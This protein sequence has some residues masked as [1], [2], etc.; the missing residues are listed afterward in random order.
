MIRGKVRKCLLG[1]FLVVVVVTAAVNV[2]ANFIPVSGPL[3]SPN[4][5]T[6]RLALAAVVAVGAILTVA[7]VFGRQKRSKE[8]PWESS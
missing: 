6:N 2:S 5:V 7:K 4:S 3:G 1:A 8:K